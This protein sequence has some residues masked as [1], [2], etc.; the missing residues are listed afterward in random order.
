M[1]L[2]RE[3]SELAYLWKAPHRIAGDKLRAAI[4]KVP[5]TPLD[6]AVARTLRELGAIAQPQKS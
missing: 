2:P 5:H 4:G 6:A 3:L 1:P